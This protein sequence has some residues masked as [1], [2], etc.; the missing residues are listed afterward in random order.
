MLQVRYDVQL[1]A[2]GHQ[3]VGAA[4]GNRN[5]RSRCCNGV[6]HDVWLHYRPVMFHGE[7]LKG[8]YN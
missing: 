4:G 3:G 6:P 1:G 8:L 2:V 7:I 5:G